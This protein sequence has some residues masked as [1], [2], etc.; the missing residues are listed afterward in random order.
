MGQHLFLFGGGPPFTIKLAQRFNNLIYKTGPI[1][2]LVVERDGWEQY[3]PNYTRALEERGL[4][5]FSFIPLPSTPIKNVTNQLNQSAGIIIGGGDTSKYADYIVDTRIAETIQARYAAG[6]PVAG[7]SAGALISLEHC[8]ISDQDRLECERAQRPGL[9]LLKQVLIAVH[10]SQWREEAH[11]KKIAATF[12]DS[13]VYG[14]DENT[15]IYFHN[16]ICTEMEG[17]GVYLVEEAGLQKIH[18]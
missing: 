4:Q 1:S 10:F 12:T 7:F 11:A 16:G 5:H 14:I 6:V 13:T 18:G 3:I 9:G 17:K 2:I 15:G 8:V